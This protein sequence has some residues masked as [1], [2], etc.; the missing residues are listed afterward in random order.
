MYFSN[1]NTSIINEWTG[2]IFSY[3]VWDLG[4]ILRKMRIGSFSHYYLQ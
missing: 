1:R 4:F 3:Y 2:Y